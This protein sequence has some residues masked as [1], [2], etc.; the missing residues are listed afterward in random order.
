MFGL[1]KKAKQSVTRDWPESAPWFDQT[2]KQNERLRAQYARNPEVDEL[3]QRLT[4]VA[5][6]AAVTNATVCTS[7]ILRLYKRAGTASPRSQGMGKVYR[8]NT[9]EAKRMQRGRYG[10]KVADFTQGGAEMQEVTSAPILDFLAKPNPMWPGEQLA[11]S[12]FYLMWACGNAYELLE[13]GAAWPLEALYVRVMV[14]D[15]NELA[16][17]YGRSGQ[18]WGTYTA[19][20]VVHYKLRPNP[21]SPLYGM[22]AINGVLP[23]ADLITDTLVHN[24]NMAKNGMRPDAVVTFSEGTND[25][26]IKEF[27]RRAKSRFVGVNRWNNWL[28]LIGGATFTPTTY[29]EKQ[30]MSQEKVEHAEKIIRDAFGHTET[31]VNGGDTSYAAALVGYSDQFLGGVI[32]PTLMMD[33]SQLSSRLLPMFGLDPDVYALA[34]DPLVTKDEKIENEML[35]LDTAAGILTINEARIER[36]LEKSD[37]ENANKLMFNGVPLGGIAPTDP[38]GGLLGSIGSGRPT[39]PENPASEPPAE[40]PEPDATPGAAVA[41]GTQTDPEPQKRFDAKSIMEDHESIRWLPC[42]CCDQTKAVDDE[43]GSD[44]LSEAL[45]EHAGSVQSISLNVLTEMQN[46]VLSAKESGRDPNLQAIIDSAATKYEDVLGDIVRMGVNSALNG[47]GGVLAGFSV[48]QE[49]FNL[50][51][52]R[53]IRFLEGYSFE[54]AGEI[55]DTTLQ[56]TEAAVSRGLEQGLSIRQIAS[57]IEGFPEYRATAIARTETGRALNAG[58]REA[59]IAV[60]VEKHKVLTAPGVRA[61]HRAIAAKGAIPIDEPFVKAGETYADE[62]FSRDIMVPPFGVNCRCGVVAAED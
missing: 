8:A 18:T 12:R 3:L 26:T 14:D 46:E 34:Y 56:M 7:A 58:A 4:G 11:W 42:D 23:Y 20:Q 28:Y 32:E 39:E 16:Y 38:F 50:A 37:D 17:I 15:N 27:D 43:A 29:P 2:I 41:E 47:D 13:N 30:L 24:V 55:A 53:A 60:G 36:G 45:R 61:S 21:M 52:E 33:A 57:E 59:M 5:H 48:P 62:T 54:L 6:N 19:D 25:D 40:S 49:A 31:M 9:I 44:L 10:R 51:P 22:G 1:L 35:R